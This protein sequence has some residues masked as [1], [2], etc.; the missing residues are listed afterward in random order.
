MGAC[1]ALAESVQQN[2]LRSTYNEL[3][4]PH[5]CDCVGERL[6]AVL[7]PGLG[8]TRSQLAR[9][10]I[11]CSSSGIIDT[12]QRAKLYYSRTSEKRI[13]QETPCCCVQREPREAGPQRLDTTRYYLNQSDS[14]LQWNQAVL[15][16]CG[17]VFSVVD[18]IMTF[19]VPVL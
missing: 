12:L 7:C 2:L 16:L 8:S 1:V 18:V 9:A 4:P 5:A 15:L 6:F 17:F 19:N 14:K 3:C 10:A 13:T 11:S